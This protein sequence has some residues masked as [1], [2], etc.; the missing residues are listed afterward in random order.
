VGDLV[1]EETPDELLLPAAGQS[2]KVQWHD[3]HDT[4]PQAAEEVLY[5]YWLVFTTVTRRKG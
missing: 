5:L 2:R 3:Y 1:V 4:L